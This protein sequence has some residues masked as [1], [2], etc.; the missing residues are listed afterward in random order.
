MAWVAPKSWG[1]DFPAICGGIF[2]HQAP[3]RA[4]GSVAVRCPI[5]LAQRLHIPN[6]IGCRSI[7]ILTMPHQL[8]ILA[9]ILLLGMPTTG[10]PPSTLSSAV[11]KG[12]QG[13]KGS[14]VVL[15]LVDGRVLAS[16]D[17][18]RAARRRVRPGSAIKPFVLATLIDSGALRDEPGVY[19]TRKLSIGG[20]KLDCGHPQTGE[21]LHA[22]EALAYSCNSYFTEMGARLT[23]VQLQQGLMRWG[24]ASPTGLAKD[25]ASGEIKL[26]HT[27]EQIQLQS[28]GEE[29]VL[30]TPLGLLNGFRRL[31]LE[32]RAG[33]EAAGAHAIVF[34]GMEAATEYGM[35]RL[36]QP[37][38]VGC[39]GRSLRVAGKTGTSKALEGSWTHAWFAGFAP[40][41]HPEIVFVIFL[42]QGAGPTDAAP[43]A[44]KIFEAWAIGS[45][46]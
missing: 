17:I 20:R 7:R 1:V 6:S 31:A 38:E 30:V 29:N 41:E 21:R 25:E 35:A 33:G 8:R 28:V 4:S 43:L 13:R 37:A 16:Y 46:R 10:L 5:I 23:G 19:C 9:L 27:R 36:A 3:P 14:V 22:E 42:E 34:S 44:R 11:M 45:A 40:S 32:R 26:A 18:V 24:L 39:N 2:V 12:M 15:D